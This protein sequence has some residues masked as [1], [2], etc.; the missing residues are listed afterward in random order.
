M[1]ISAIYIQVTHL[2][3]AIFGEYVWVLDLYTSLI[4][5]NLKIYVLAGFEPAE[6]PSEA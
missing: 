5:F 3:I 6:E 1:W 2:N 4:I